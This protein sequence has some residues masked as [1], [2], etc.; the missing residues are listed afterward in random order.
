VTHRD[1]TT[2]SEQVQRAALVQPNG[3]VLWPFEM[4]AA[5]VNALANTGEVVLGLDARERHDLG[6]STEVALS[7]YRSIAGPEESDIEL[8][9]REALHVLA[10]AE[11]ITGWVKPNIL[12]TW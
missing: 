7:A 2:L 12:I 9:R 1:L 3:E 10:Q 8:A 5:A 11:G 4:A 6:L